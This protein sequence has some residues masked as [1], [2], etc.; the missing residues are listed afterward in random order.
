MASAPY[1]DRSKIRY[2]CRCRCGA[3]R[4]IVGSQLLTGKSTQC[5]S[6][7]LAMTHKKKTTHGATRNARPTPEYRCWLMIRRR[8]GNPK[9]EHFPYYGGRGISVSP[10]WDDFEAF[11]ADMGPRPSSKHSI[12]RLDNAGNYG[13]GNCVWATAKEQGRNKRNNRIVRFRGKEMPLSAAVEMLG[14][15]SAG[16]FYFKASLRL[17]RGW[18]DERALSTP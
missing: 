12:E 13:P 17:R 6:C 3:E 11:L 15:P 4:P 16:A 2:I 9:D 14:H 10:A 8:C 1:R 18:S 7:Q 5:H